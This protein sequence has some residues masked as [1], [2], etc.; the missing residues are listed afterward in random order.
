TWWPVQSRTGHYLAS[1]SQLRCNRR[2][3]VTDLTQIHPP[4]PT[5]GYRRC[6]GCVGDNAGGAWHR[7]ERTRNVYL[8]LCIQ[9]ILVCAWNNAWNR[10][11]MMNMEYRRIQESVYK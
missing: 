2:R 9:R 3:M 11:R 4:P 7:L 8:A 1:T 10:H 6:R 5:F